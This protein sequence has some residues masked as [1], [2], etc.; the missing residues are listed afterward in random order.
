MIWSNYQQ[1]MPVAVFL[2]STLASVV[3][4]HRGDRR[5]GQYWAYLGSGMLLMQLDRLMS[6][7]PPG[8][9]IAGALLMLLGG[10]IYLGRFHSLID[11]RRYPKPAT[12]PDPE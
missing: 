3:S 4:F 8:V 7:T 2:M 11:W 1:V 12:E 10:V 9:F 6:S 5:H